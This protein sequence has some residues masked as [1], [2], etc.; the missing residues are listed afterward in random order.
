MLSL[1]NAMDETEL[2]AFDE[3]IRKELGT[4][5]AVEYVAEPKLDGLGVVSFTKLGAVDRSGYWCRRGRA[6]PTR[7]G[8]AW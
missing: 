5:K 1:A 7:P 8:G 2:I 6:R 3:R 4:G